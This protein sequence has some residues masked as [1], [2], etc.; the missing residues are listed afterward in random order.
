MLT[1]T[2]WL[3]LEISAGQV[4]RIFNTDFS[5]V[6]RTFLFSSLALSI[7]CQKGYTR[8]LQ[9]GI[10]KS[11]NNRV[12]KWYRHKHFIF[13]ITNLTVIFRRKKKQDEKCFHAQNLTFC[14]QS[15]ITYCRSYALMILF[16]T[17]RTK[18]FLEP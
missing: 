15:V 14:H 10:P 16:L 2:F 4:S 6:S 9:C 5:F 11:E 13:E 18:P 17:S 1:L 8:I 12:P 7:E 3:T